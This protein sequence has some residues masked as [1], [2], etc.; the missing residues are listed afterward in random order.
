MEKKENWKKRLK[1][2]IIVT[3]VCA[4]I[5][6]IVW[7]EGLH[8]FI[9]HTYTWFV[10]YQSFRLVEHNSLYPDKLPKG[11]S[12]KRYYYYEG[13]FDKNSAVSF[14]IKDEKDYVDLKNQYEELFRSYES[15]NKTKYVN[16]DN[17]FY[18]FDENI[19]NANFRKNENEILEKNFIKGSKGYK[20]VASERFENSD[21]I[22]IDGVICNDSKREIIIFDFWDSDPNYEE[23]E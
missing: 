7:R 16:A 5:W 10:N 12:D 2:L 23:N 18:C 15:K 11:V 17:I 8:R 1:P 20:V 3:V 14:V 19:E 9:P 4:I 22:S 6:F 21:S 13:F